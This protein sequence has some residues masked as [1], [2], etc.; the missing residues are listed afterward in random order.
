MRTQT[1][2]FAILA[3]TSGPSLGE[4]YPLVLMGRTPATWGTPQFPDLPAEIAARP[5]LEKFIRWGGPVAEADKA[6]VYRLASV[7]IFPSRYEGFGLGPLEAMAAGTPVVAA[8]ASSI[9]EVCGEGAYLV[10]PDDARALGGAIIATLIQDDLRE[11]LRNFGLAR[12]SNFS[13][14]RTARETL[15]VYEQ[16]LAKQPYD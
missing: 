2:A 10:D 5:G 7:C 8:N 14:L 9:P 1:I 16:T 15:R 11:S 12:A 4:D 13:W 3:F 6:A